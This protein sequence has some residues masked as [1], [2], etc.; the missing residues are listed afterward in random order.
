[1]CSKI[2]K[3]DVVILTY[4]PDDRLID[5]LKMLIRQSVKP[6]RIIICNTDANLFCERINYKVELEEI[7]NKYSDEKLD[8]SIKLIHIRKE[9]FDHG[10]TRNFAASHSNADYILFLTDD[11]IPLNN[12]LS[13]NLIDA[14][15]K[16]STLDSNVAVSYAKQVARN[17]ATLKERLIR[18]YNYPDYDIIKEKCKENTYGI[19]NYFCSNV[20]AM[21]DKKIFDNFNGFEENIILNED[22]FYVYNAIKSGY[23]IVYVSN[24]LVSHSHNY[25]HSRQMNRNFDIGVSHEEKKQIFDLIPSEN[26]GKK[27]ALTVAKRLI[28]GLHFASLIDFLLDCVYRLYG[29]KLG[30]KFKTLSIDDC[31]KYADNKYYFIKKKNEI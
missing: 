28:M 13:K 24:A 6:N 25:T 17:D 19:K 4:K 22:T 5:S 21:Y 3:Y 29:Y 8:L 30:R 15:D 14:F 11:A 12:D 20:C 1:M 27:M 2:K 16:Y 26:E 23:R 7:I 31:I 9:E 18:E 10:R